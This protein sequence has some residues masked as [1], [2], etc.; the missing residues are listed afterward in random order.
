MFLIFPAD[1]IVK[2]INYNISL[3]AWSRKGC[4]DCI[5]TETNNL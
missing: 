5:E 1:A 2:N 3:P 4:E